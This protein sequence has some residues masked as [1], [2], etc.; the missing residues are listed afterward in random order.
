MCTGCGPG[1]AATA[2]PTANPNFLWAYDFVFDAMAV[3]QQIKCL[4]VV[5]EFTRACLAIAIADSIRSR[6][7]IEALSHLVS[8]HVAPL[9]MRSDNGPEFVS[10]TVLDWIAQSSIATTPIDP[11][12]A[13][14]E[15]QQ[16][17]L[18]RQAARRMHRSSGTACAPKPRP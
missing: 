6:R 14:A 11:W 4:T 18:R 3:G 17:E 15:R 16:R 2:T 9:F 7:V 1:R 5:D 13:L 8:T 12:Q 10:R